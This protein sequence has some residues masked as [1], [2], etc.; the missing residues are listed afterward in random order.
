MPLYDYK[1]PKHG[2]FHD[3]ATFEESSAPKACP[4]CQTSSP[5]I[6]M[7]PPEVLAMAPDKRKAMSI[8][9]KSR[10]EPAFSTVDSREDQI[11]EH[12]HTKNCGCSS[13]KGL[14][15][16]HPDRS[17]LRQQVIL[18]QDGSKVFPS[19]RPWMISH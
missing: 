1:C 13:N 8:N 12:K 10:H 6:I 15:L 5:R 9:E 19:Q 4:H 14:F 17:S 2:I 11:L 18:M 16:K 3:L 7:I